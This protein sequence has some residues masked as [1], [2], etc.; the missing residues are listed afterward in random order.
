MRT[1]LLAFTVAAVFPVSDAA[2]PSAKPV[3]P[4]VSA[5]GKQPEKLFLW[6]VV[7]KTATVYLFGTLHQG[8]PD[9]YP[10]PAEVYDAFGR[11]RALA[12]EFNLAAQDRRTFDELLSE[13]CFYPEG[14][15]LSKSV[16]KDTMDQLRRFHEK[17][18]FNLAD[19]E[20][21]RPWKAWRELSGLNERPKKA[22]SDQLG[23]D[24]HLIQRAVEVSKP[25]WELESMDDAVWF[26]AL[27]A[28]LQETL[29]RVTLAD[30]NANRDFPVDAL[31]GGL[32][33]GRCP[34][35]RADHHRRPSPT[36]PRIPGR[37]SENAGRAQ[38]QDGEEN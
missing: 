4:S 36:A 1:L 32:A 28:E 24:K 6:T 19:L 23:V 29:L 38:R 30:R 16:S 20:R 34:G 35:D 2:E 12:V 31:G 37:S 22:W 10:L 5:P 3:N 33:S 13:R 9:L 11:S 21:S 7:S 27:S 15:S 25:V 26:T 8:H 18:D 17:R 14:E